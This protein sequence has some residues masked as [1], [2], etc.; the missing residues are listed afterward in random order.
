MLVEHL[1]TRDLSSEPSDL[2][3]TQQL[4]GRLLLLLL[5]QSLLLL[6]VLQHFLMIALVGNRIVHPEVFHR[7]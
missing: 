2:K 3:R 7:R 1:L 5:Q 6:L 4:V